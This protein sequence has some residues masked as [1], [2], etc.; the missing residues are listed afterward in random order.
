MH[1]N[2]FVYLGQAVS[3]GGE[4]P[5]PR[6]QDAAQSSLS[7]TMGGRQVVVQVISQGLPV[8]R[9]G[10]GGEERRRGGG[11]TQFVHGRS[12]MTIDLR[13]PTMPGRSTSSFHQPG[14]KCLHQARSSRE[15]FGESHEGRTASFQEP[16]VKRTSAPCAYFLAYG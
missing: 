7:A 1:R 8:A 11:G 2:V 16:I 3:K 6:F 9:G 15:V 10:S 12:R 5:R 14:R 4:G 13:I